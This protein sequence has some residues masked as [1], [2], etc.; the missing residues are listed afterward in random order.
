MQNLYEQ[1]GGV[2]RT[3]G[4]VEKG[5]SMKLA[6]GLKLH[7]IVHTK[8]LHLCANLHCSCSELRLHLGYMLHRLS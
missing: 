7:A 8:H 6:V 5:L 3:A 4:Y 1:Q 2:L